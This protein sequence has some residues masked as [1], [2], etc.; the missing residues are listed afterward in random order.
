MTRCIH[1]RY[2]LFI[3]SWE[4][5]FRLDIAA[6]DTEPLNRD[7]IWAKLQ[8]SKEAGFLMGASCGAGN[9]NRDDTEYHRYGLR[10][11]HAYSVLD[12]RTER[13]G[14]GNQVRYCCGTA[15][16]NHAIFNV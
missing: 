10:P 6:S 5:N 16:V 11:R 14:D 4:S 15:S 12:V 3:P 13:M 9:S 8:T 1:L 7:E 2:R